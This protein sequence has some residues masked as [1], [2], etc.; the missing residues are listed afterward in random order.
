[1]TTE[2]TPAVAAELVYQGINL[3]E[4]AD[5]PVIDSTT[6]CPRCGHDEA[7]VLCPAESTGF[8]ETCCKCG[9]TFVDP[10]P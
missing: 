2:P 10:T 8:V 1:M 3:A 7:T 4:L 9:F 5:A 6:T